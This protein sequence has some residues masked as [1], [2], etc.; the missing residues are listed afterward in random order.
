[1]RKRHGNGTRDRGRG[2]TSTRKVENDIW[3]SG[4]LV[5]FD[6]GDGPCT[7]RTQGVVVVE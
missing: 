4:V 7:L 3:E 6:Y 2:I 1:M 5:V